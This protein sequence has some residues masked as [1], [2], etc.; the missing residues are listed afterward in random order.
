MDIKRNNDLNPL[1]MREISLGDKDMFVLPPTPC[2][3]RRAEF[4]RRGNT[5][6]GFYA[7]I[8]MASKMG[9]DV[10]AG[11]EKRGELKDST[12]LR[13]QLGI[14]GQLHV[15]NYGLYKKL[16]ATAGA[17]LTNQVFLMLYGSFEAYVGDL[18]MDGLTQMGTEPDPYQK[19]LEL[20]ILSKWEGKID[21]ISMKLNAPLGKGAFSAKFKDIDL[22][23]FNE[24]CRSP[25]EFL[26]KAAELRHLLV[27]SCGRVDDAFLMAH[28]KI[29]LAIGQTVSLPFG[30]PLQL[31]LFFS[32]LSEVFDEA[33]SST[34]GWQ[35]TL[36]APETLT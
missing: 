3:T 17:H 7:A 21:R 1:N 13:G 25:I 24:S 31:Q 30:L 34:F 5:I 18:V 16:F 9:Q 12:P 15:M 36:V 14:G 4:L 6:L 29:G 33:F 8:A 26:E 23:F 28:P 2:S 19:A 22:G 11:A 10:I 27:H 35:R 20:M 32:H